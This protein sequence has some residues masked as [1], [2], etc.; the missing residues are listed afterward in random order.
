ML[1]R[2]RRWLIMRDP[3]IRYIVNVGVDDIPEVE[4]PVTPSA[5][6]LG[7]AGSNIERA[8]RFLD[9]EDAL[10]YFLQGMEDKVEYEARLIGARGGLILLLARSP[11]KLEGPWLLVTEG[12]EGWVGRMLVYNGVVTGAQVLTKTGPLY[13]RRALEHIDEAGGSVRVVAIRLRKRLADWDPGRLSVYVKGIDRQHM[14]LIANLNMLY[15]GLVAGE[16]RGALE[17]VLKNLGEYTRFHFRSEERLMDKFTYPEELAEKH[18]REHRSFVDKVENYIEKYREGSA[19]LTLDLL[20]YLASWLQ[21]HI[22]GSD[23]RFGK[24]LKFEARA[25]ITD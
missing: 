22:A 7:A 4:D 8:S 18:R 6:L 2:I 14:F 19:E 24:W 16:D 11:V 13:G 3:D 21:G 10:K 1:R 17:E 20:A 23:R 12:E 9:S 25:P 15:L 5:S